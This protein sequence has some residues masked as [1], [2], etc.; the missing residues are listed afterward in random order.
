MKIKVNRVIFICWI[1][2][3]EKTITTSSD[4][5]TGVSAKALLEKMYLKNKI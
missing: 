4:K 5:E 1:F 3:Y 2:N